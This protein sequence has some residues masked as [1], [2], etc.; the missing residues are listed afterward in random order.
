[1][2]RREVC[3]MLVSGTWFVQG[4]DVEIQLVR[5]LH[6]RIK[7]HQDIKDA[8]AMKPYAQ[9]LSGATISFEMIPIPRGTFLMGSPSTELGRG[10]DEGP[11]RRVNIEP[12]WMGKCEV[13]WDEY[14]LFTFPVEAVEEDGKADAITRPTKPFVDMSFGMGHDGYPAISMTWHA[15]NKYCQWLSAKTERFHRLPTEAE[16]EYACRAGTTT[17]YSFK[18]SLDQ[19]AWYAENSGGKYHPVGTK[20]PNPWGLH[21]MHGNVVEWT[22]DQYAA[23]AYQ[24]FRDDVLNPWKKATR[25]YPHSVRGGSWADAAPLLRSA[26][27]RGSDPS[28]KMQ[29][30]QLPKSIW[31]HTDAPWVGFRVIRPLK[32]PSAEEMFKY[33][34]GPTGDPVR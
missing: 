16:W 14:D 12:F 20:K 32:V 8:A 7:E 9:R 26:A 22:L 2:Q 25:P 5:K 11:Q 13:A 34:N 1:M 23:E 28:W 3:A 10:E 33:W 18:G 24:T 17:P 30:P 4:E 15:A 19:Y 6:Q 31:Y 27:R 29:D 21:D